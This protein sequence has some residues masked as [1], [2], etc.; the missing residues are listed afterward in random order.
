MKQNIKFW[1]IAGFFIVSALGVLLHF[2]FGWTENAVIATFSSVNESTWEHMKL[3]FFPMVVF[4]IIEN[5]I[6][7]KDYQN[8][9]CVKLKGILLGLLLIPTLFYTLGGIFGKTPDYINIAIFFVA[10]AIAF[11]YETKR[12]LKG[13]PCKYK[14][15]AIIVLCLIAVAF[16]VFTFASP[17]IPFFQ[18]PIS[19]NYGI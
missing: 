14:K 5:F 4:A 16:M 12:F 3:L 10:V 1:Q 18:D 17:Q 13:T 2:L 11:I 7:G 19:Q 8:F 6:V 9:W 15:L